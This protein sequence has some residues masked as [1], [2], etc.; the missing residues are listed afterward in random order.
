MTR[1]IK[2][3]IRLELSNLFSV[4]VLR[5]TRDPKARRKGRLMA[6]IY[7]IL[8]LILCFY[9]GA[10]SY[11]LVALGAAAAVPA[12][13]IAV[14]S[15]FIFFFGTFTAGGTLFRRSGYDIICSLP[16]SRSAIVVSRFVRMYVENLVFTLVVMVPGLGVYAILRQPGAGFYLTVVMSIPAV[17][18]LPVAAAALAGALVTGIS[19]RMKHKSL[20]EAALS[21]LVVLGVFCLMPGTEMEG[22]VSPEAVA[23]MV[24]KVQDLIGN[25]YPPAGWFG[26]AMVNGNVTAWLG[27]FAVSA[28][29]FSAVVSVV[30]VFFREICSRLFG[31]SAKHDYRMEE[32]KR[33][34]LLGS[35]CRR[36]FRRYFSSGVYVTNT[37]M[38]PV[39]GT[40]LSGSVFFLGTARI[41]LSLPLPVD[42]SGVLPILVGGVFC[43]M[44]AAA[45][46]VSMEGKQFW[47]VKTL[48]I[49]TKA[50][51]DAKI[52]M[53]LLLILPFYL[54]SEVFLILTL[55][56]DVVALIWL[57][58]IPAEIAVF[59]CVYGIAINL[60][61]PVLEW[62]H[63]VSVVKQSGAS[64]LGGM[65]GM[66]L[67]ILWVI[68][69]IAVPEAYADAAKLAV[70]VIVLVITVLLYRKNN[71][72]DLKKL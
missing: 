30:S 68:A 3:L 20:V 4:N 66:L 10:M 48:P 1:Q 52:L 59:S 42:I 61:L 62:E 29:G 35:M 17:P 41:A 49:S 53:N 67:A 36:E 57:L 44:T 2:P 39:M 45:V 63:E 56:P 11:G 23:A 5:H 24:G 22:D 13:L 43:L 21:I 71:Q 33:N 69:I 25:L 40:V 26:S 46:S 7:G 27:S 15:I 58:V 31:S 9:M 64:L 28:A 51:L 72:T 54:V 65:G 8:I 34:S 16:V 70:A 14:A 50:I 6:V 18:L 37:I 38:G 55:K 32:L 60:R 12:Y 19:S 47:I